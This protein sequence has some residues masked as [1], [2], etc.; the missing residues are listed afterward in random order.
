MTPVL[1][2]SQ[3]VETTNGFNYAK[4]KLITQSIVSQNVRGLK[5]NYRMEELISNFNRRDLLAACIQETWR[6]GTE[7]IEVGQSRLILAGLEKTG[8]IGKRGSQG[9]GIVLGQAGVN[10]WKAAGAVVHNDLGARV[11]ATR[12]LLQDCQHRNV[13]V[14]LVSAYAPIGAAEQSEWDVYYERLDMCIARKNNND[15]LVIGSDTNASMGVRNMTTADDRSRSVVGKFG[16]EHSNFS[17]QRFASFLQTNNLLAVTTFFKKRQYATWKHPRSKLLHQIDHIITEAGQFHRFTDAG[18]T[19]CLVDSDHCAIRCKIRIMRRLKRRD[20]PRQHLLKLDYEQLN[21]IEIRTKFCREVFD[22]Y[23]K[24]SPSDCHYTRVTNALHG[25]ALK[26]IPKRKRAQPGWFATAEASLLPLIQARNEAFIASFRR[27]TRSNTTRLKII[28]KKIKSIVTAEKN[29]WV[30]KKCEDI[31]WSI[32]SS[33]G[34][35][36]CWDMISTLQN[37]LSKTR[38]ATERM[39]KKDDGTTCK[40]PDENAEVFRKHFQEV[41]NR[42]PTYNPTILNMLNQKQTVEGCEHTPTDEEICAAVRKLKNKAP[43]DS[44]LCPQLWKAMLEDVGTFQ[45]LKLLIVN[46]WNEE[47]PPAEWEIGQ[48]RIIP[49]KGDLSMAT[50]YR[51]IMLLEAA[52]KVVAILLHER[53]L[54]IEE[55]IEQESQC[56][57][58]PGRGTMDAIFTVKMAMKKRKEHGLETWIMFLDL[59]KAF[60]R[61]PRELLW[62][63]LRKFGVPE[64]LMKL[65]IALHKNT[66]VKFTVNDI[67]HTIK[68]TIGVKQGDI[69]GPILFTIYLAAVMITWRIKHERPLCLF[70]T[71]ED[72]VLTG[73][74]SNMKGEEFSIA[75]SEYAD[76]TA[77]L[78]ETRKQVVE[79]VPSLIAHFRQWGLE[80]HV[81]NSAKESKTVIL[82]VAAPAKTYEQPD[83]YDNCDLSNIDLGNGCYLPVVDQ[84][85]YL[86]SIMTRNCKD[87]NDVEARINAAGN[88]F[89]ALRKDLFA[90]KRICYGAKKIVFEGIVLSILLY[91]AECW[92]LQEEL[93]N[94]LCVFFARCLRGMC[95]VNRTNTYTYRISNEQLR[96]RIGVASIDAYVTRR[97]LRWAGHVSRMSWE[98]LPRK[99]L[100]SWVRNKRPV[101][102]PQYTYGRGLYKG[103]KRISRATYNWFK[104]A[105]DRELWRKEVNSIF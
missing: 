68:C 85:Q 70:S 104:S 57:F 53:L 74:R 23:H 50:N 8:V 93:Y 100:S 62:E 36:S 7:I 84:F 41:Y 76:D 95:R 16:L 42:Q 3:A 46:F 43:G 17:G 20:P 58:R 4:R 60:D 61:V 54:P 59:V 47:I 22:K 18:I 51:G 6:T 26:N 33:R 28:R 24:S 56:G 44:G 92:C 71:K 86:G 80:V 5:S 73:R 75:D 1:A 82:F 102:A 98:R 10:A 77:V 81:G 55:N 103:L 13:G 94:K 2:V 45:L 32:T 19:E 29:K 37:G 90:S 96:E 30:L 31:N 97:Q 83:T 35:K 49:K 64:K 101:G 21:K 48:L 105:A 34:T 39:M 11:I 52:Y 40:S 91:G 66:T 9:V 65:L 72:F 12:L 79:S 69:L 63:V 88:A 67:T 15:I 99:M 38:P 25:A 89:G 87:D 14:F 78:F 27:N